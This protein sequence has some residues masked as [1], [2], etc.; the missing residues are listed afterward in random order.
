MGK[1]SL[2][3]AIVYLSPGLGVLW[4]PVPRDWTK[5]YWEESQVTCFLCSFYLSPY[6]M[7]SQE[8]GALAGVLVDLRALGNANNWLVQVR[9]AGLL[10][11]FGFIIRE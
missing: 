4:F 8:L 5:T 3:A 1:H 10:Q 11:K 6:P 2:L 9:A 7:N